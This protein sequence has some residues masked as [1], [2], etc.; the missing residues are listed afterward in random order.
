MGGQFVPKERQALDNSLARF[1]MTHKAALFSDANGG[2]AKSGRRDTGGSACVP[3]TNIAAIL[4]ES[5]WRVGLFPEE[6]EAAVLKTFQE[7]LILG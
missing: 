2:E 5:G 7:L 6:K 3:D 1:G 4:G